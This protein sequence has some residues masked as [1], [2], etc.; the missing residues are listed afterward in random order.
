MLVLPAGA[1]FLYS[2]PQEA[3][4]GVLGGVVVVL[5]VWNIAMVEHSRRAL[6]KPGVG[7]IFTAIAGLLG[8]AFAT[9]GPGMVAY[10][11]A[12][13]EDRMRAKSNVQFYFLVMSVGILA[14][15]LVAGTLSASVALHSRGHARRISRGS[16]FREGR[17]RTVPYRD[18]CG[19]H[20][21][22]ALSG[23]KCAPLGYQEAC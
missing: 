16:R 5:T 15:H 22:G 9:P 3:I 11:Y 10:L 8:G 21:G 1:Y 12:S 18:G 19:A 14:T 20:C 4:T 7:Y 2:L 17:C 6:G 13:D 23:G